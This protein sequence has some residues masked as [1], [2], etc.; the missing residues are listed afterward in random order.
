MP[1]MKINVSKNRDGTGGKDQKEIKTR[2][3]FIFCSFSWG[4]A[5]GKQ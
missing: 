5:A 3:M 1:D 4:T 2:L